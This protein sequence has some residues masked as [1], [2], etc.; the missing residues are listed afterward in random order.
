MQHLMNLVQHTAVSVFLYW[1][2]FTNAPDIQLLLKMKKCVLVS[3]GQSTS[4]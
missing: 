1:T 4:S 2:I 3:S